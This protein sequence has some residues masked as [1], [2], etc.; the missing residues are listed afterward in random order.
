MNEEYDNPER[1]HYDVCPLEHCPMCGG[2][3]HPDKENEHL[4]CEEEVKEMF[5]DCETCGDN[6]FR[7]FDC[8]DC[9]RM[10]W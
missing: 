5:P 10:S 2:C 1:T 8:P 3:I 6:G 7:S 4:K 9:G